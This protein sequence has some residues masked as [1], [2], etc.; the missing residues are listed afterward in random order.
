MGI[1]T[2]SAQV[3]DAAQGHGAAYEG[4]ATLALTQRIVSVGHGG[5]ILLSQTTRDLGRVVGNHQLFIL[6]RWAL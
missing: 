3:K 1:H 5:Q 6:A 2:G 4:Y